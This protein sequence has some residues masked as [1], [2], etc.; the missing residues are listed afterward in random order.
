MRKQKKLYTIWQHGN[1]GSSLGFGSKIPRF[2]NGVLIEKENT[3][4]ISF[5]AHSL[6]EAFAKYD[7]YILDGTV[8]KKQNMY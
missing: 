2:D 1:H 5:F 3:K 8:W 6:K 4:I 7:Q